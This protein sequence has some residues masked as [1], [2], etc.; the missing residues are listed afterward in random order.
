MNAHDKGS[1]PAHGTP[2]P[3]SQGS[4]GQGHSM[5]WVVMA[6]SGGA[7]SAVFMAGLAVPS[8]LSLFLFFLV[9]APLFMVGLAFGWRA[10]AIGA[11]AALA[12][13]AGMLGPKAALMHALLAGGPA[14]WL[15]RLARQHRPGAGAVEGEPVDEAGAEW[16]PEGR[17]LLWMAG[18]AA[19]GISISLLTQGLSLAEV[20]A[21]LRRLAEQGMQAA[22]LGADLTPDQRAEFLTLF[23]KM[24][25]LG[26]AIMWLLSLWFSYRLAAWLTRR[27]GLSRRPAG[28]FSRLAFPRTAL[29][30]LAVLSLAALLPGLPGLIGEVFAVSFMAAFAM[31]GLAVIHYW[32]KDQPFQPIALGALYAALMLLTGL[33]GPVLL[34]IG[35][36]EAGFGIRHLWQ[37]PKGNT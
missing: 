10:A 24:A 11:L 5:P 18:L 27:F 15:S 37:G 16:Y 1:P 21:A 36:A 32:L 6:I 8:V 2:P 35:L 33:V 19:G 20:E 14:A 17:L 7:L 9:S 26:A 12:A 31:L 23:V 29:L 28:D 30:G 4:P 22:G 13:L 3:G 25:P 34:L